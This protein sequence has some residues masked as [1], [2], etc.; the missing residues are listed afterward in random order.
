MKYIRFLGTLGEDLRI[1]NGVLIDSE[2]MTYYSCGQE[3]ASVSV[4]DP[5]SSNFP[6]FHTDMRHKFISAAS[7]AETCANGVKRGFKIGEIVIDEF[8]A[9]E[10]FTLNDCFAK[11]FIKQKSEGEKN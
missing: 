7:D 9:C 1:N 3:I 11:E 10:G 8:L 6:Q 5:K 4:N 2:R